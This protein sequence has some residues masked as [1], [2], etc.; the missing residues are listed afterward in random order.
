MMPVYLPHSLDGLWSCLDEV[1]KAIL[2][3]GG[4]DVMVKL[5]GG[6][7]SSVGLICLERVSEICGV[8]DRKDWIRIGATT[9]HAQLLDNPLVNAHLGVLWQAIKHLG[10]P[11][12]RA[13]GTI[14]GNICTASPAGDTL[15]P[16]FVLQA[17]VEL[18]SRQYSRTMAIR[19]FIRGPGVNAL[20]PGEILAAVR[21][22]KPQGDTIHHFEKVGRRNALACSLAS[23]AALMRVSADGMVEQA[24]L[25]WG[26]VAPGIAVVPEVERFLVGKRLSREVLE[27]AAAVVRT[28]VTPIDDVR[29]SADYRRLVAG[30]L[31][32]RLLDWR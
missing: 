32:L 5:R 25:A 17:E 24:T 8:E 2:Y 14:G 28:A 7:E 6:L 27:A 30:N 19:D 10:S 9:N 13:M 26:S 29:A 1:P 23:L 4:T 22:R 31:V 16:L 18:I 20:Q 12:I 11:P 21:V 15:P 3:A